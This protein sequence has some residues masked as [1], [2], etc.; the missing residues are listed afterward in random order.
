ML[1]DPPFKLIDIDDHHAKAS[2]FDMILIVWKKET[3]A[4]AYERLI[5]LVTEMGERHPEGIGV[6]QVVETTAIPPDEAARKVFLKALNV[7]DKY[8][9]H[10]SV[11]HEGTGFK[12]A[13]VRAI[14]MG[15]YLVRQPKFEHLVANSLLRAAQ[16]HEAEQRKLGKTQAAEHIVRSVEMIRDMLA[17]RP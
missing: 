16:W 9:K 6:L 10:Y 3:Q 8:V 7:C 1:T 11:T 13:S 17:R 15:V 4:S 2:A 5:T 12:A 14:V